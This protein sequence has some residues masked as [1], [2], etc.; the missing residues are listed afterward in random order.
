M[1]S[2]P[3]DIA[4]YAN[5]P[6]ADNDAQ[7]DVTLFP[8]PKSFEST[9]KELDESPNEH[10]DSALSDAALSDSS[11][12]GLSD[13]DLPDSALSDSALSDSALSDSALSDEGAGESQAELGLLA[14]AIQDPTVLALFNGNQNLAAIT[15]NKTDATQAE[16]GETLTT[17]FES[18]KTE[19]AE[20]NAVTENDTD[21][22]QAEVGETLATTFE[23][24]AAKTAEDNAAPGVEDSNLDA[25]PLAAITSE[26]SDTSQSNLSV[27]SESVNRVLD[28]SAVSES[29]TSASSAEAASEAVPISERERSTTVQDT[30]SDIVDEGG[31]LDVDSNE[32]VDTPSNQAF[33][34]DQNQ[35]DSDS[36]GLDSNDVSTTTVK[37]SEST[38]ELQ[39]TSEVVASVESPS[40]LP[41]MN[42]VGNA[43]QPFVDPS[44]SIEANS[45]VNQNSALGQQTPAAATLQVSQ[46]FQTKFNSFNDEP[47]QSISIELNPPELGQIQITVEQS[48]DQ[49]VARII[50]TEFYSTE[51]LLQ[52]KDFL[53]E[54][55]SDLGFGETSL[56]ISHGG[57][58][59]HLPNEEQE[60]N[61]PR[62]YK[63]ASLTKETG[64]IVQ[65][66]IIGVNFIA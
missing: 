59:Q 17:T 11:D 30:K 27:D 34:Q 35:Q 65:T 2:F 62:K 66:N 4:A 21:A 26:V 15:D 33:E 16:I 61:L 36:T 32:S 55:L 63:A 40:A 12:A 28:N 38:P 45:L 48:A 44:F 52:E 50:A 20:N 58:E 5:A 13:S 51:L 29:V 3:I 47:K 7:T 22:T 56:D 8:P 57:S 1:N 6:A 41:E 46:A 49:M 10:A 14:H 9:L 31:T 24:R 53:L 37:R 64:S 60:N 42:G 19:T 23:S 39:A 25:H 43:A 18:P 54:A